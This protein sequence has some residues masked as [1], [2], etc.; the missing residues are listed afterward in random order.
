[1]NRD[2]SKLCTP[3][4]VYFAIAVIASVFALFNGFSV[5]SVLLKIFFAFI[6]TFVLGWLCD[7][8]Y[9]TI[10]W[11]L[12][13]L[14]YIMIVLVMMGM[15]RNGMMSYNMMGNNMMGYGMMGNNMMMREGYK[16]MMDKK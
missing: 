16:K 8:G 12:V 2:F 3:A 11:V 9:K 7:K 4:K 14:P 10:S 15:M 5:L 6:W 1:M 13:L